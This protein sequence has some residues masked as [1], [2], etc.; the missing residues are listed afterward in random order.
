MRTRSSAPG[1][2][3]RAGWA[4][5]AIRT[6]WTGRPL[7]SGGEF[8]IGKLR[9]E[10][11]NERLKRGHAVGEALALVFSLVLVVFFV[12]VL[13]LFLCRIGGTRREKRQGE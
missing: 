12:I 1:G 4:I 11:G 2:T 6:A 9:L 5:S 13:A 10:R 3:R 7:R 8:Y